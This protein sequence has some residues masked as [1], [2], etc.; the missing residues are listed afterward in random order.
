M[1]EKEEKGGC[2]ETLNEAERPYIGG[3]LD[4]VL[5]ERIFTHSKLSS[6][7]QILTNLY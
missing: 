7:S 2:F 6:P 5:W 3:D 1:K 4:R